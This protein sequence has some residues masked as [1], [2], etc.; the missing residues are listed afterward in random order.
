MMARRYG[1]RLVRHLSGSLAAR[2]DKT[3]CRS[4]QSL[5]VSSG[6]GSIP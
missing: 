6:S 1:V 4:A 2:W 3:R 5:T